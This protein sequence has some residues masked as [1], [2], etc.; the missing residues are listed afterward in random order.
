MEN[1]NID[2][3]VEFFKHIE[4]FFDIKKQTELKPK[5]NLLELEIDSLSRKNK[6][7]TILIDALQYKIT[8]IL[9]ENKKLK[10]K[11]TLLKELENYQ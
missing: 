10:E 1:N 9:E 11:I 6:E 7:L 4:S 3:S 5:I 2:L 8:Y